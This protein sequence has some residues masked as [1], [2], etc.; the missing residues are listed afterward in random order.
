MKIYDDCKF[1]IATSQ[2]HTTD[3]FGGESHTYLFIGFAVGVSE[4]FLNIHLSAPHIQT[5]LVSVHFLD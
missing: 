5:Y 4:C 1:I 2:Y 3:Y